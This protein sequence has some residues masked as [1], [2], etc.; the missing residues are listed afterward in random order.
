M[1]IEMYIHTYTLIYTYMQ[2]C[3]SL[4]LLSREIDGHAQAQEPP[5]GRAQQ[6]RG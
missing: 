1:Y 2:Y 6:L 5:S 4:I 3:H